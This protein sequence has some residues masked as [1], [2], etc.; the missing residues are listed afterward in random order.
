MAVK[1]EIQLTE[2]QRTA[3]E[4]KGKNILVSAAAGS[5][6]T[7]VLVERVISHLLSDQEPCDI[8]RLLVVTFTEKAAFEMKNRIREA[9]QKAADRNP[10]NQRIA[11][12][13]SFLE[14][15][16]IS[17]IHAFC[18]NIVKKYFYKVDLDP[19]FRVLDSNEAELLRYEALDDVFEN[20]YKTDTEKHEIF[21]QMVE[22]YGGYRVDESLKL[23]VLKFHD[24]LRAL[25]NP[26]KW[27]EH[28]Y[29][30]QEQLKAVVSF[31][32]KDLGKEINSNDTND[33][34]KY[35]SEVLLKLPWTGLLIESL[36][37]ELNQCLASLQKAVNIC[38]M[39][40][41]PRHY[42]SVVKKEVL[43]FKQM[44]ET[45]EMLQKRDGNL[46]EKLSAL[47]KLKTISDFKFSRL[48][49]RKT[50][51][52][53]RNLLDLAKEFRDQ[54]KES[55]KKCTLNIIMRPAC[56]LLTEAASLTPIIQS[57][58][59]VVFDLDRV[60]TNKKKL[61]V[62]VDFS[63]L[64]KYT[65]EILT[66]TQEQ[67]AREISSSYDHVFVD[68][69]QDTNPVQEEI[70]S[71]IS[72][73][74]NLFM[75]GDIKQSIYRF[76]LADPGIF[77][78]KYQ[79]YK[80]IDEENAKFQRS[81]GIKAELSK[82]FRS[83]A[84]VIH[85]INFLFE[86]IMKR[87]IAE[88]D[89]TQD[90]R[91]YLGSNY[92]ERKQVSFNPELILIER[93]DAL[94]IE[95]SDDL[96]NVDAQL[97][98][99]L[100][101][102]ALVVADKIKQLVES[103]NSFEIWDAKNS[104]FRKCAFKDIAVLMRSIKGRANVVVDIFERCGI[105]VYSE[106]GSGYFR[107]REVEVAL[108]L[109]AI[110]DNPRQDIPLAAVLRSS[111][112]G[113]TPKQLAVIKI[114]CN[115]GAFYD[116]VMTFGTTSFIDSA[117][118]S[119]LVDEEVSW[120]EVCKLHKTLSEFLEDLNRWRTMFRQTPLTHA[121]WTVLKE[122]KYYDYVGGLPG[123]GQ[124]QA[125][126][127]SL[128]DRAME[129]DN[130][131]RHGLFRFLRFI[132]RI[133]ESEGDLGSASP[134]GEQED[135]VKVLSIHKSKGLQFPVV[136][137]M[138]LGKQFNMQDLRD[139]ILF[140]KD[141]G[142]GVMYC[143]L[144]TRVKYP[145]L[146]F[147]A[148][149]IQIKKDNIAEEMR[150]LYVAVTRAMEKLYLVGSA[151]NLIRQLANWEYNALDKAKTYLDWICP[152]VLPK[153]KAFVNKTKSIEDVQTSI[154]FDVFIYGY[155]GVSPLPQPFLKRESGILNVWNKV[156]RLE[157]QAFSRAPDVYNE[158]KRRLEWNYAFRPSIYTPA[159]MSVSELKNR[160][161]FENDWP[162]R[163]SSPEKRLA[164]CHSKVSY[165]AQR[166]VAIHE[167]L[168][169]IDLKTA[170]CEDKIIKEID[171][172]S[173]MGIIDK[174]HLRTDDAF[175]ISQ[176]FKTP[177]GQ[178]LV[179]SP[180]KVERELP[181]SIKVN[182]KYKCSA[183]A[184]KILQSGDQGCSDVIL[185]LSQKP[186][187][188]RGEKEL[189]SFDKKLEDWVLIQGIIDVIVETDHGLL[190]LDYKT[191]N[192]TSDQIPQAAQKYAP[193]VALY[194]YALEKILQ[195]SLI[196]TSLVFL[197]PGKEVEI[198]WRTQISDMSMS[199]ILP[200]VRDTQI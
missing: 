80:R 18:L 54:A 45:V 42:L 51:H 103:Q 63:D 86:R 192:L 123:G 11:R 194:A 92:P 22:S 120:Q 108:S 115:E 40:K 143:D 27:L 139:D 135:V 107:Q 191:D 130:F 134:V 160:L 159:K 95:N 190:V 116:S 146:P 117:Q 137:V 149:Q 1:E 2:E 156:K 179:T 112:V 36:R 180:E 176:F 9:L 173:A 37:S 59:D 155:P 52:V 158:I 88:I 111:V 38:V 127:R 199:Q 124:R 142:L 6:K 35:V 82:N 200:L 8:E 122:T 85:G 77:I 110:I 168:A 147:K 61:Q 23:M 71:L 24:F 43:F 126:L 145:T 78:Q 44:G 153:I 21:S 138:D 81:S 183:H 57:F 55:F 12:Q 72:S 119:P 98:E 189:D 91:L 109:L 102:E 157:P 14:R 131:G 154:P 53:D 198:D 56:D 10:H 7:F 64:E 144:D 188:T 49:S 101:K 195:I 90:H 33:G 181:F 141:I 164:F 174:Q 65:L 60:Y 94:N 171:K 46:A 62:G 58:I 89:Y 197:T 100:E 114:M 79:N 31:N 13:L 34:K 47:E 73:E 125:N 68:E 148:N 41:G 105:P 5:G 19:N 140:H 136:F 67:L 30:L 128:I 16:Q 182:L 163:F 4:S 185:V 186:T 129:F 161:D 48:P 26:Q 177:T 118:S 133:Q 162:E 184:E 121:L 39:P 175:R 69:Y 113:L 83:R 172:I 97:Y 167:L 15:A 50:N 66:R 84:E 87:E 106:L 104:R 29:N 166:G 93:E 152:V 193:Q 99:A 3:I 28:V 178:I 151:K 70:L 150:V 170:D 74:N 25:P 32:A 20:Y 196:R 96:S 187:F 132:R 169:R 17:T 76:R 165:G 75:V